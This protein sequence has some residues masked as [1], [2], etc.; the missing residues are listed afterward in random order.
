MIP[1]RAP[2]SYPGRKPE[3]QSNSENEQVDE[4]KD[5][6]E[7][8]SSYQDLL[9]KWHGKAK[10]FVEFYSLLFLPWDENF[11]PRDPS[12]PELQI[13][14][15]NETTSWKNFTTVF[16]GMDVDTQ[17][18][19][20]NRDWFKRS[21]YKLF[22]NM[23]ANLIQSSRARKLVLAWRAQVADKKV[24]DGSNNSNSGNTTSEGIT[25]LKEADNDDAGDDV[26]LVIDLLR[27]QHGQDSGRANERSKMIKQYLEEQIRNMQDVYEVSEIDNTSV[28]EAHSEVTLK[29]S[30]RPHMNLTTEECKL[31]IANLKAELKTK[32]EELVSVQSAM[33][34]E[35]MEITNLIDEASEEVDEQAIEISLDNKQKRN[36]GQKQKIIMSKEQKKVINK[37]KSELQNSDQLLVMIQG[38]TGSGKSTVATEFTKELD[39]KAIFSATTGT[40]AAPLKAL[41]VNSLLALGLS[42]DC[43]DLTKDTTSNQ[44]KAKLQRIFRHINVLIIDEISMCTPVT[45][46]RIDNRLR[47]CLNPNKPLGNLHVILLGDFWQFCF[48]PEKACSLSSFGSAS[49][50]SSS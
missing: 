14:P 4:E 36:V 42:K 44:M 15:Y 48:V 7:I 21:T 45:L 43:V 8:E 13:L 37:L 11:D 25:D 41:T 2:P 6:S 17:G 1:G 33:E 26:Q 31:T 30:S 9:V 3:L 29:L 32:E 18:T 39:L 27:K 22:T 46:A 35:N 34:Q 49:S 19:N 10:A 12:N 16:R 38:E 24:D 20:D 28:V 5:T 23:A 40:S 47:E 50:Q